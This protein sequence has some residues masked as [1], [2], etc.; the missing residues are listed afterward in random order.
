VSKTVTPQK[1]LNLR[2]CAGEDTAPAALVKG[3]GELGTAV[4]LALWRGGWRV[5]VGELP[6]PTVLGRQLSLAEAAFAG[7]VVR[8]GARA[9]RVGD[10]ADAVTLTWQVAT[11]P[12]YVGPLPT[13]IGALRP[14]LVVDARMRRG[15]EP[16]PQRHDARLVVGLGPELVAGQHVDLVI[17]T[18]PGSD[19][20]R[21]IA[22][23]TARPHAPLRR[24][25]AGGAEEYVHAARGGQWRTERAIGEHVTQGDLLGWLD[26][27]A[28]RA[29]IDGCLRGLVHD[30]VAA[31]T[32]MKL[33][34]VH[35]GDWQR[36][37]AGI[38]HRAAIIA[39]SVL[40]ALA[41]H[42]VSSAV[43]MPVLGVAAAVAAP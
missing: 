23:G 29:P 32:G 26:D 17:E 1:L 10:P 38:G 37:E 42:G 43:P 6:K 4:A 19:L 5:V 2:T 20:G 3:G 24:A 39:A 15:I 13:L 7:S 22:G 8:E 40:K 31:T 35:P 16:E 33:A 27:A 14:T 36:K 11:I 21:I 28:V 18:C 30:G 9:V 25:S 41:E 12:L 34:A